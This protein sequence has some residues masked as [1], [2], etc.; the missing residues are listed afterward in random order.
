MQEIMQ[1]Y[2]PVYRSGKLM[3]EGKN[4]LNYLID[5][6]KN[7]KIS[8]K[9]TIWNT[10]IIEAYELQNLLLQSMASIDS[11][12][13]RK[14]SRGAHARED[15]PDRDDENWLKH[16]LFWGDVTDYKVTHRPVRMTTLSNQISVIQPQVRVY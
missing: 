9:S 8:D 7:I 11:A 6:F 1:N 13:N 15:F 12:L 2:C 3:K 5:E 10:E 4:K 16:T 14:E